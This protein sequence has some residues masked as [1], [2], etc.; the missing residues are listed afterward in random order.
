[1]LT[2]LAG[3]GQTSQGVGWSLELTM[4]LDGAF[5]FCFAFLDLAH[6]F[7]HN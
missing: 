1:M 5:C 4:G 6:S 2:G 7:N 3:A